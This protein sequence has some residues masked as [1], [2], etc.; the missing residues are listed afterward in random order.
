MVKTCAG[1]SRSHNDPE[2]MSR[3]MINGSIVLSAASF[4]QPV[5]AG[6]VPLIFG[7]M[8]LD[9]FLKE[10]T[11]AANNNI[12]ISN[13]KPLKVIIKTGTHTHTN[14][15]GPSTAGKLNGSAGV[16]D[17][18]GSEVINGKMFL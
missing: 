16:D 2:R 1:D 5:V 8:S 18:G 9:A 17:V 6:V 10:V 7:K 15:Y 11:A 4:E 3:T 13:R 14:F 12:S